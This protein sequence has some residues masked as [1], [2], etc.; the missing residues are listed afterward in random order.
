MIFLS[1]ASAVT[2]MG[3]MPLE[4]M[5][6]AKCSVRMATPQHT[7]R[8]QHHGLW[9]HAAPLQNTERI[10]SRK[11]TPKYT[12]RTSNTKKDMNKEYTISH[13]RITFRFFVCVWGSCN[14]VWGGQR[15]LYSVLGP[16]DPN[17]MHYPH[18]CKN[19]EQLYLFQCRFGFLSA[20]F[21]PLKGRFGGFECRFCERE[22]R[23]KI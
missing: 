10:E 8:P 2:I 17:I 4:S 18:L 16:H 21:C 6:G 11:H 1:K 22:K 3:T 15:V 5:S 14:V 19:Q 20:G 13:V 12:S 7:A 9:D 23:N